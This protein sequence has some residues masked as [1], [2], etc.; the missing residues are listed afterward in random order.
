MN[1]NLAELEAVDVDPEGWPILTDGRGNITEGVGYNVFIVTGGGIRTAGERRILP[2]GSPGMVVGPAREPRIPILGE[3]L[4]PRHPHN[5]QDA[6]VP[7]PGP[8]RLP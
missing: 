1:F 5:P 6:L 7:K 4:P 3:D 8:V 2:G